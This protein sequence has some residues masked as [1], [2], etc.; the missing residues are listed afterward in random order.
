MRREPARPDG[1]A[2]PDGLPFSGVPEA[3]LTRVRGGAYA[4]TEDWGALFSEGRLRTRAVVVDARCGVEHTAF[5]RMTAAACHELPVFRTRSDRVDM[6]VA[7]A[8]SRH[9]SIDVV[10]HHEPLPEADVAVVDGLRVTSLER[11]VY[12]VIR[13]ATME[14]AIVIYDAALRRV[15]WDD[16]TR[17]YDH[18]KAEAF[19]ALIDARIAGA[20]GARGIRQAR[21]ISAI[22]DG[23]AQLPGE[24]VTRLWMLLLGVPAPELQYRIDFSDGTFSLLDFAWPERGRW[25]EFDGVFKVTDPDL[26]A[27]RTVEEVLADQTTREEKVK[28][29]TGWHCDR[30]GFDRMPTIDAFAKY[31][32]SIGLR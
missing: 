13:T 26:M 12:D 10:R 22:A 8:H 7:S 27:G 15:A 20:S 31:L 16:H 24:S 2:I 3:E 6:I 25:M 23:R 30:H 29:L 17:T 11:T 21:F 4:L 19:R 1:S 32:R 9:N 18:A 28:C 14:A 5:C